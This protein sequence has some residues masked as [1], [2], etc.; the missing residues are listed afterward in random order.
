MDIRRWHIT[1][2]LMACALLTLLLKPDLL[3]TLFIIFFMGIVPG[4][5]ITLPWWATL[6]VFAIALLFS[7][8]WLLTRPGYHAVTTAK[9]RSDRHAAR[10]RVLKQ[11]ATRSKH[12]QRRYKKQTAKA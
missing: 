4:T 9:D 11:T 3:S 8:R 7:I 12:P 1:T 10:K 5:A 2:A 6:S